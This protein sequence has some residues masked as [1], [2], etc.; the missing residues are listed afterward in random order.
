VPWRGSTVCGL[1]FCDEHSEFSELPT[2]PILTLI[3]IK[4]YVAKE[5][6]YTEGRLRQIV[7]EISVIFLN[8]RKITFPY[9]ETCKEDG[10]AKE[11]RERLGLKSAAGV[12]QKVSTYDLIS[13]R[14]VEND[15][16]RKKE[17]KAS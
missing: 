6:N 1:I 7:K 16:D 5:Y 4:D 17:G 14:G 3:R 13:T 8:M 9:K 15:T 10:M 11:T 2:K 12:K